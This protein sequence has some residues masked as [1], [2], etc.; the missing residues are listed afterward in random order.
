MNNPLVASAF[1]GV[2]V[3]FVSLAMRKA[4]FGRGL[5]YLGV[6]VGAINI[7][8]ALPFFAGHPFTTGVAFVAVS[9]AWIFGVGYKVY[10]QPKLTPGT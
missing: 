2:G 6:V 10:R 5:A 7:V 3:I 4:P 1:I 9:S 8:R